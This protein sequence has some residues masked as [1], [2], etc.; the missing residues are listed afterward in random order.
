MRR[1]IILSPIVGLVAA[2]LLASWPLPASAQLYRSD[3]EWQR[4]V[5]QEVQQMRALDEA[6]T[7]IY[8]AERQHRIAD[9]QREED[10]R[11]E[12]DSL[13]NDLE[14]LRR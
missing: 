5:D 13:R 14:S 12:M 3:Q 8:Q 4:A 2:V 1:S 6:R 7:L 9:S 11:R 10:H